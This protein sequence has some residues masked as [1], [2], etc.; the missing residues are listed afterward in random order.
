MTSRSVKIVIAGGGTGGH[1]IPA[2]AVA[3]ELVVQGGNVRFIGVK[4]RIESKL[5]PAAG[6]GIDFIKV[7]P[8]KGGG[9]TGLALG[10]GAIP[11]SSLQAASLLGKLSPSAVLG[12]GGYVAG[13]VVLAAKMAGIPTAILEQNA[14]VGLTNILLAKI[15]DRAFVSY[16]ETLD[17]FPPGRGEVTGNPVRRAIIEAAAEKQLSQDKSRVRIVVMGGSQGA[18]AIDER[19]PAALSAKNLSNEITVL[20]Q[21]GSGNESIVRAAYNEAQINAEVTRFIDNTAAAYRDADLVISRSGATTIAELT[22]M[23][24]PA[25]LLPYPHHTDHQ[26][27]KNARPMKREGAAKVLD[28]K[29]TDINDLAAAIEPFVRDADYRKKAAR[30]SSALG[31]PGATS[32]VVNG[33]LSLAKAGR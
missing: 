4:N 32:L 9:L 31:R 16:E 29:S 30:A 11:L 10:I 12:V 23:G 19:V 27:E 24:L 25:V 1:V 21:C 2:I 26:Q 7:K 22:V 15:V 28:E 8:L 20:H 33:L 18:N 3:E 17:A 6:F 5:V 13:P 14:T